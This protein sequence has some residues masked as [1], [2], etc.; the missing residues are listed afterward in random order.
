R[1][2]VLQA[3]PRSLC[4][5]FAACTT[6]QQRAAHLAT[7]F[8]NLSSTTGLI[9]AGSYLVG[10]IG[11]AGEGITLGGDTPI[12]ITFASMGVVFGGVSTASGEAAAALRSFA[13]G[14]L[15][16]LHRFNFQHIV[17]KGTEKL[18]SHWLGHYA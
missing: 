11:V 9:S 12:T 8:D 6:A 17:E 16:A 13:R 7:A 2:R 15:A 5:Q 14:D 10:L 4:Q 1:R 3:Q 18:A